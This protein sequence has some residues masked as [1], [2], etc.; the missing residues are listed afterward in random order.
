MVEQFRRDRDEALASLDE[1][2]IREFFRKYNAGSLS[3]RPAM[4]W[5]TV[6]RY[7]TAIR[8]LPTE[9]RVASKKWLTDRGLEPM[10]NGELP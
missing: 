4:F 5:E 7:I 9:L 8:S 2:R 3:R 6:H 10:D 1:E